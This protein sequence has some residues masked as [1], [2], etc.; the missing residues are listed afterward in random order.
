MGRIRSVHPG[1]ATDEAVLECSPLARYLLIVLGTEADDY[2]C[3]DWKPLRIKVRLLPADN[4]NAED[5]LADLERVGL[6]RRYEI[7]GR[8]Y[9][10]IRNFCKWQ[11]PKKPK[12]HFPRTPEINVYIHL[13]EKS[14]E[15]GTSKTGGSP[16]LDVSEGGSGSELDATEAGSGSA[17][18]GNLSAEGRK[19]GREEGRKGDPPLVPPDPDSEPKRKRRLPDDVPGEHD[20]D[21]AQAYW[22]QKG[23]SDLSFED[24]ARQFRDYHLAK[25]TRFVDWGAAWRTWYSRAIEYSRPPP[26]RRAPDDDRSP[27]MKAALR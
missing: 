23:R 27:L 9:G 19:G 2:G 10:A 20:R 14:S 13:T 5:V 21:L 12:E 25:G 17:K 24:Q 3:F 6:I 15:L 7:D 18:V 11:R 22:R 26:G 16:E 1:L 8:P 4:V